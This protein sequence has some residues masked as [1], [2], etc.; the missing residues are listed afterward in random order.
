MLHMVGGW[1]ELIMNYEG[2]MVLLKQNPQVLLFKTTQMLWGF[3][4]K[5]NTCIIAMPSSS[6]CKNFSLDCNKILELGNTL[7]PIADSVHYS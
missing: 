2:D 4:W 1:E 5:L 3:F 7:T 6:L